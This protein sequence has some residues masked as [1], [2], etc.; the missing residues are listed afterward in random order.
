MNRMVSND[1]KAL[2]NARVT[3]M[4]DHVEARLEDRRDD[5]I[6]A[7]GELTEEQSRQ[8][9]IDAWTIGLR[10]LMNAFAQGRESR[11]QD[12]GQSLLD[13]IDRQ[14]RRHVECQQ[15][16]ITAVLLK[17]F[18]PADGQVTQRLSAFVDDDGALARLLEKY[19]APQHS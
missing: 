18:D 3:V 19:L 8:L 13:D 11:L 17:F 7:F 9:A 5:A 12:I 4:A 10:A 15:Q 6:R 16:T 14:L 2:T 1:S